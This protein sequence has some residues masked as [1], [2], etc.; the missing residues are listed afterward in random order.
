VK[1]VNRAGG[2]GGDRSGRLAGDAGPSVLVRGGAGVESQSMTNVHT[3]RNPGVPTCA[4]VGSAQHLLRAGIR[5]DL[6][7][8]AL[9][10]EVGL[11]ADEAKLAWN[12]VVAN[13]CCA[14]GGAQ[15]AAI[16]WDRRDQT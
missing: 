9:C 16:K 6:A 3:Y 14:S 2:A 12:W 4:G 5:E 1:V 13:G 15:A 8:A 7:I 11:S 10:R